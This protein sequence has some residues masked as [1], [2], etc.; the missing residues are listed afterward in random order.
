MNDRIQKSSIGSLDNFDV[1]NFGENDQVYGCKVYDINSNCLYC[2]R[3]QYLANNLCVSIGFNNLIQNCNIYLDATSC[4]QCDAQYQVSTG[5]KSCSFV[6]VVQNCNRWNNQKICIG[7]S[8]GSNL[9]NGVC[10]LPLA[11]CD[12]LAS[13]TTCLQ[14]RAGFY[15]SQIT[16]LCVVVTNLFQN[17]ILYN[18]NSK[19][20]KCALGWAF[21]E[22]SGLCLDITQ[23]NSEIDPNCQD[24]IISNSNYCN[25]CRQGYYLNVDSSSGALSC[26]SKNPAD[27]SCYIADFTDQT[28][29]IVCM[30][31]YNM[32]NSICQVNQAVVPSGQVDPLATSSVISSLIVFIS[33][34]LLLN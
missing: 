27:E 25:I 22:V 13:P 4:Y 33:M 12:L 28:K 21:D 24:T 8:S 26:L 10:S 34:M 18:S 20:T 15:V 23:V 5:N 16:G 14:C 17:C 32:I 29:C 30:P 7:C 31:G 1:L 9:V 6:G 2:T 3:D 19:C 11:N